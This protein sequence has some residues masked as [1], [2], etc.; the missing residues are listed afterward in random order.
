MAD[1]NQAKMIENSEALKNMSLDEINS[2]L[3]SNDDSIIT[4]ARENKNLNKEKDRRFK[5]LEKESKKTK[6]TN[7][8]F[9]KKEA[10]FN[11]PSDVPK[12]IYQ[13]I[14]TAI[15]KNKL[16]EDKIKELVDLKED[17]KMPRRMITSIIHDYIKN[18]K[19]NKEDNT[20][21]YNPDEEL[22]KLFKIQD[23][24][25]VT[26]FN[27]QT[28]LSR[29]YPDKPSDK[30]KSSKTKTKT[31]IEEVIKADSDSVASD[32]TTQDIDGADNKSEDEESEEEEIKPVK[33]AK[34][35]SKA[36]SKNI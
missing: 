2:K 13:F 31:N 17:T 34:K 29:A 6:K 21:I 5:K 16:S 10:G 25:N 27:I 11:M 32:A 14:K 7:P 3:A 33:V 23:D 30:K 15:S 26:F 1:N 19:L 28:Y 35:P 4:L 36:V 20:R 8:D 9:P 22:N 24:E 18:N 12:S